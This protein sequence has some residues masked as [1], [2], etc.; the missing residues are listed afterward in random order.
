MSRNH[1]EPTESWLDFGPTPVWLLDQW[2]RIA[3]NATKSSTRRSYARASR[4]CEG[5]SVVLFTEQIDYALPGVLQP[6][7]DL[8]MGFQQRG[9]SPRY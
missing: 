9:Y 2:V 6:L 4:P 8:L 3:L 5:L 1:T 7:L